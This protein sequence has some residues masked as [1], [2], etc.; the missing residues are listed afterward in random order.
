MFEVSHSN[1][2]AFKGFV[3]I[4]GVTFDYSPDNECKIKPPDSG[5]HTPTDPPGSEPTNADFETDWCGWSEDS[6]L[7]SEENFAWNR[8]RGADQ[9]GV[10]GPQLDYDESSQSNIQVIDRSH[11]FSFD[12]VISSGH[13]DPKEQQK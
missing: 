1:S 13:L 8:T 12:Q 6:G 3:A 7:N 9:D 5:T 2:E 4:D 10:N 11:M